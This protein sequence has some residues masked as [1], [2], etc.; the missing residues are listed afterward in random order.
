MLAIKAQFDYAQDFSEGLAAV[1]IGNGGKGAKW[2]F[3]DRSGEMVIKPEFDGAAGFSERLCAV[4]VGGGMME[5]GKLGYIDKTGEMV[6][7]PQ[8]QAPFVIGPLS[9]E[10]YS[11]AFVG[12]FSE[13]LAAV[14]DS[15]CDKCGYIDQTGKMVIEL[16]GKRLFP[17]GPFSEGLA[18]VV[19]TGPESP[20]PF[21][22]DGV[23]VGYI[24]K[25]GKVVIGPQFGWVDADFMPDE[26]GEAWWGWTQRSSGPM[27]FSEGLAAV[28]S[29]PE[30][31]YIDKTGKYVW[32]PQE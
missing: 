18:P 8:F 11:I 32:R 27:A 20:V 29:F 5:G 31:G 23:R 1:R 21:I 13:G 26:A 7:E 15:D 16:R 3:I 25:S 30:W 2:G 19:E 6:I 14:L 24:D 4:R 17:A 22:R 9:L 12:C 28:T 10:P